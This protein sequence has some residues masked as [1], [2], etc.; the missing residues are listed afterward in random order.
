[1]HRRCLPAVGPCSW[2]RPGRWFD[3]A[4]T[5]ERGACEHATRRENTGDRDGP[6]EQA[7]R[8]VTAAMPIADIAATV[9]GR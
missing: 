4:G 3:V 5:S 9:S 6:D 8:R 7:Q 2:D 1:M